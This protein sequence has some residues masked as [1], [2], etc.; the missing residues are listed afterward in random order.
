MRGFSDVWWML[1]ARNTAE[2][3]LPWPSCFLLKNMAGAIASW[4]QCKV[5]T[6]YQVLIKL[7]S[8]WDFSWKDGGMATEWADYIPPITKAICLIHVSS[9]II[10]SACPTW[11][12]CNVY[13]SA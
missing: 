12:Y 7:L 4:V 6:M 10:I 5:S 1:A 11:S 13:S 2:Y 3:Y 9:D 8:A